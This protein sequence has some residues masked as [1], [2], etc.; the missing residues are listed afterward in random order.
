M[1]DLEFEILE[2]LYNADSYCIS[3]SDL[4]TPYISQ[5]DEA[6]AYIYN[7]TKTGI[8]KDDSQN[9]LYYLTKKDGLYAYLSEY[10]QRKKRADE[11]AKQRAYQ[12]SQARQ[13]DNNLKKQF[14][15][16]FIIVIISATLGTF[17]TYLTKLIPQ[18]FNAFKSLF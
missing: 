8:I 9:L 5:V 17:L 1:S 16:D 7:F 14:H 12:E 13:T 2:K 10:E 4:L 18:F 15:H 11:E 6:K 3:Y